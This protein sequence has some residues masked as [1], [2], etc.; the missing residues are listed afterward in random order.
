MCE[1]VQSFKFLGVHISADLSWTENTTALVKKA[2]QRLHF[3]RVLWK[4]HLDTQLLVTFYRSSIES[5]L[6]Y[7]VTVWYSSCTEADR[8]RLQRVVKNATGNHR[9]PSALL[10]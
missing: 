8:K 7:A 10:A 3:L 4:E 1:K 9:L 6:T 2:Q 5:V